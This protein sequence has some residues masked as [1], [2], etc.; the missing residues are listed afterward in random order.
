M[1]PTRSATAHSQVLDKPVRRPLLHWS[2]LFD[3]GAEKILA[4]LLS[5]VLVWLVGRELRQDLHSA[6]FAIVLPGEERFGPTDVIHVRLDASVAGNYRLRWPE[7]APEPVVRVEIRGQR[8]LRQQIEQP[9]VLEAWLRRARFSAVQ[10]EVWTPIDIDAGDL[11]LQGFDDLQI[12]LGRVFT[13]EAARLETRPMRLD[14]RLEPGVRHRGQTIVGVEFSP[15]SV[16]VRAPL[17][18]FAGISRISVPIDPTLRT[19]VLGRAALG[20]EGFDLVDPAEVEV[21][22]R[23]ERRTGLLKL[24]RVPIRL[25]VAPDAAYRP[26]LSDINSR[27]ALVMLEGPLAEVERLGGDPERREALRNQL[28]LLVFV[29]DARQ[30]SGVVPGPDA[31]VRAEAH[32]RRLP[33]GLEG[34]RQQPLTIDVTLEP[35]P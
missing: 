6:E 7:G 11:R 29:E 26:R 12:E 14:A 9:V 32:L 4:L 15:S 20:A 34:F 19:Q 10:G 13:V 35:R 5:T 24:Q 21:T 25:V 23:L 28:E 8:K 1:T 17:P 27:G 3:H 16:S 30:A 18:T 31:V 33:P 2:R 22:L